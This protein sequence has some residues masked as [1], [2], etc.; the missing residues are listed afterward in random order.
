MD[1]RIRKKCDHMSNFV[2]V[3]A[4]DA[5]PPGARIHHDFAEE[6]VIVLNIG[7]ELYCI[8]DLCTHDGGP[9]E[10]GELHDHQIECPR[11]G[12]C[13]DVRNGKVTRL[14]AIESIPTYGVKVVDGEIY[15]EEPD[16][17]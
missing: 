12:A 5:L 15:V 2:R 16:S 9:L 14:P 11:H 6:S 4:A 7:G 1:Y 17:W 13:F 8:A 10:D 3:A